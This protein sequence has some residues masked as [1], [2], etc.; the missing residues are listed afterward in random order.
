MLTIDFQKLDIRPGF[1]IL[2]AGCG[3]GRHICE[4]Y[5][6]KNVDVVG[7]DLNTDDLRKAT[8]TLSAMYRE[9]PD[10]RGLCI[11]SMA[12][13][14]RL[15]FK[16]E[17]FDLVICSEVLEHIPDNMAAIKELVRVLKPGRNLVVSVPRFLPERICWAISESYH[18]VQGGHIRI[19]KKKEFKKYWRMQERDVGVFIINIRCILPIGG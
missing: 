2:D 9:D 5:R 15:P 14:T 18:H 13:L 11:M 7:I 17:T 16:D 1:R 6:S 8:D 12:D 3:T 10:N 19:Y 4:A